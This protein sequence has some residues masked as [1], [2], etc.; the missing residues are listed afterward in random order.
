MT[1]PSPGEPLRVFRLAGGI[2]GRPE[3]IDAATFAEVGALELQH[4]EQWLKKE[5]SVLGEELLIL[6]SQLSGFDKTRDRPDLLAL[7][8]SGKLV[9]VEIKRDETGSAQDLQALRYAAYVSTLQADQVVEL[10]RIYRREEHGESLQ[11]EQA[12][13]QLEE[14]AGGEPLEAL[15]EDE[16]PRMILVAPGFRAGVTNTALWL[17]R[18]FGLDITCVQL[19]PY[20]VDGS[21]LL[22]STV[23]IPLPE[24]ADYEVRLQQKRRRA[25]EARE[26][27]KLDF[28]AAR[29]FIAG[30]PPGRWTT[31][32]EVAV[33]AG[34]P[35]GAQAVGTWLLRTGG[36]PNVWRVLNRHGEVSQY[37]T[38]TS[39][40]VPPDQAAAIEQLRSEGIRFD[41]SG[42]ADPE[43]R[44]TMKDAPTQS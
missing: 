6:A 5:P 39:P 38:G 14:F 44:W 41:A 19:V 40:G 1:V 23:L 22:T 43:Q 34:S 15:D 27:K 35:R 3:S 20:S 32:G 2:E 13:A 37:F 18:N 33:A 16:Q 31:Y 24:A 26:G 12:R 29:E 21:L 7:D 36:I 9:V 17:I 28:E 25:S 4:V 30:V 10:F 42:R 8:T 11:L